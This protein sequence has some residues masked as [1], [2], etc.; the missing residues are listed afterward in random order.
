MHGRFRP[1][2]L[3]GVPCLFLYFLVSRALEEL[4]ALQALDSKGE[5]TQLGKTDTHTHTYV[6]RES[7]S[8][9]PG[10]IRV[11]GRQM[12]MFPLE[13]SLSRVL[14]SS[15]AS[16]MCSFLLLYLGCLTCV[17]LFRKGNVRMK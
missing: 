11:I 7:V 14:L 16:V 3:T 17:M 9:E 1:F 2:R 4:F 6:Q 15:K 8:V 13:P 12:A 5:L 10:F